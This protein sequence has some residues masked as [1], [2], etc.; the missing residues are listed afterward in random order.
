MRP[1]I[2]KITKAKWAGGVAQVVPA[3]QEQSPEF[4]PQTHPQ[5]KNSA[6]SWTQKFM[7]LPK[8]PSREVLLSLVHRKGKRAFRRPNC[9]L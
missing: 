8:I 9:L 7:N 1:P 4:K 3:L 6:E 2:S 5:K